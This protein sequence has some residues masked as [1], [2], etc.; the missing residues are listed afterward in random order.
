MEVVKEVGIGGVLETE[1]ANFRSDGTF[2]GE[3]EIFG[4]L[5]VVELVNGDGGAIDEEF[6]FE[7][8][9]VGVFDIVIGGESIFRFTESV[10]ESFTDGSESGEMLTI[11]GVEVKVDGGVKGGGERFGRDGSLDK[12]GIKVRVTESDDRVFSEDLIIFGESVTAVKDELYNT[13]DGG[14]GASAGVGGLGGVNT[15]GFIIMG[16]DDSEFGLNPVEYSGAFF[17]GFRDG[18]VVVEKGEGRSIAPINHFLGGEKRELC[19]TQRVAG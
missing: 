10:F 6:P 11:V 8:P 4:G 19:T 5:E 3:F 12:D 17:G 13:F 15:V 9:L 18:H 1:E 2:D 7:S 14:G 16:V